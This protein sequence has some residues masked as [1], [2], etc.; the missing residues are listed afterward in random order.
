MSDRHAQLQKDG[1][2]NNE[3]GEDSAAADEEDDFDIERLFD[4]LRES[5]RAGKLAEGR[6]PS[7]DDSVA[8]NEATD[9]SSNLVRGG[10]DTRDSRYIA[11]GSS[12]PPSKQETGIGSFSSA[13]SP[14][15]KRPR[16][17]LQHQIS[18]QKALRR[19]A[20]LSPGDETMAPPSYAVTTTMVRAKSK[21]QQNTS[22]SSQAQPGS[23]FPSQNPPSSGVETPPLHRNR[24]AE[25]YVNAPNPLL[26]DAPL[27]EVPTHIRRMIGLCTVKGLYVVSRRSLDLKAKE[28][29]K[30]GLGTEA[31]S[32]GM[33]DLFKDVQ[34]VLGLQ[35]PK[36][37]LLF[38]HLTG[39]KA[40]SAIPSLGNVH[41]KSKKEAR[42]FVDMFTG[43]K[44]GDTIILVV[45]GREGLSLDPAKWLDFYEAYID[46]RIIV[47]IE[48]PISRVDDTGLWVMSDLRQDIYL[49][50]L[51][52]DLADVLKGD[53]GSKEAHHFLSILLRAKS[54]RENRELLRSRGPN[55]NRKELAEVARL[56]TLE[57]PQCG[58][59]FYNHY[60]DWLAHRKHQ[61]E[62]NPLKKIA[63][64][65]SGPCMIA[66]CSSVEVFST[67]NAYKAHMD[68]HMAKA[69]VKEAY[70][71]ELAK[72]VGTSTP[73]DDKYP[74][75]CRRLTCPRLTR[76]HLTQGGLNG[77]LKF[78]HPN[79]WTAGLATFAPQ[80]FADDIPKAEYK[81]PTEEQGFFSGVPSDP[82]RLPDNARVN[83]IS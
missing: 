46:Y 5:H 76:W 42:Q 64:T 41:G 30:Q 81:L 53:G 7:R 16:M 32:K 22:W 62:E 78:Y 75:I 45:R 23:M 14:L 18:T 51:L 1:R 25:P 27:P 74:F 47:V 2:L 13:P 8:Q 44:T 28:K 49:I 3:D 59:L 29:K 40:K 6:K 69:G 72:I 37:R 43:R 73:D 15:P 61:L 82:P 60:L 66:G 56:E 80:L 24:P 21:H 67:H 20:A 68:G 33:V 52:R 34:K 26:V 38:T 9:L 4:T 11:A 31:P 70:N 57:C 55:M 35:V 17:N 79:V 10:D 50:F 63:Q 58:R 83:L 12:P 39:V 77:H 48:D 65:E 54:G 71:K 36:K 19:D